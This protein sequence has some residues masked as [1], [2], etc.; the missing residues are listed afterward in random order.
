MIKSVVKFSHFSSRYIPAVKFYIAN[1]FFMKIPS[2][3]LRHWFLKRAC[4]MRIGQGTSIHMGCFITGTHIEIG[5][6]SVINRGVYLDGRAGVR[7]GNNVNVSHQVLI[8]SLSHDPQSPHFN[9]EVKPVTIE[10]YVWLGARALILPGVTIGEGAVVGA[11]AVV[12][13]DVPP[14]SIVVGNPA[15][16]IKQRNR[17]LEYLPC[18]FPLFDTDIQ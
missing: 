12:S 10:D 8:Q 3:R 13:K 2:Y 16:V 9:C 18:Y 11:G 15:R 5:E 17:N 6:H 7:I 1:H 14:Y 4:Q